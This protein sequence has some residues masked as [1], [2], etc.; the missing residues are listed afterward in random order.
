MSSVIHAFETQNSLPMRQRSRL[1]RWAT[2]AALLLLLAAFAIKGFIPGWRHLNSN[3]PNYY[4]VARLYRAGYP[5]QRV[6]D[7][8]WLQ[9]EKDHQG[10]NQ[11][12]VSFMSLTPFSTLPVMPWCSLSPLEAKRRWLVLNLAFAIVVVL[13]LSRITRLGWEQV[14]LLMLLAFLPLSHNFVFGQMHL[15]VLFLITLAAWLFLRNKHFLSGM[16]LAC[17]AA[18]KIYPALFLIYFVW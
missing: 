3:F 13:L 4:L 5:L 8:T 11:G 6:Y 14:A 12:L 9:R 15:L 1:L 17:A 10:I 16:S 2:P 18:L 7:W